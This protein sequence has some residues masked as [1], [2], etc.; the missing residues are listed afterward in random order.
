MCARYPDFRKL[1]A[2]QHARLL[3][4]IYR[5]IIDDGRIKEKMARTANNAA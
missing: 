4:E 3:N 1:A 5:F 2:E